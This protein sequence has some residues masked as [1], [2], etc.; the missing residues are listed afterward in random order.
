MSASTIELL[1]M[2]RS[3]MAASRVDSAFAGITLPPMQFDTAVPDD[4][5]PFRHFAGLGITVVFSRDHQTLETIEFDR[6]FRGEIRGIRMGMTGTEVEALLGPC[7][8]T[9]PM[10]HP[11]YILIYDRPEFFRIDLSREDESV[12]SMYR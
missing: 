7:D 4:P 1:Q 5:I 3:G 11:N 8:R 10:P 6:E 9:W 2:M 12:I